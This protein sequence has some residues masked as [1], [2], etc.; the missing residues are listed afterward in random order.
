MRHWD[1][2]LPGRVLRVRYEDIVADLAENVKRI[3]EFCGLEF[4]RPCVEFYKTGRNVHTAS[5]EQVRRPIFREGLFQWRNYEPWLAE[6]KDALGDAVV[7][8]RQRD[9]AEE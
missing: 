1:A 9:V 7:R 6:L 5:S 2:V 4:E 3:L 8:Y